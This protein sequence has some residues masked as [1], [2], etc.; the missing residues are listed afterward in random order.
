LKNHEAQK[1]LEEFIQKRHLKHSKQ[2]TQI[3]ETFLKTERH[4]SADELFA[5][6]KKKI[7]TIG[8]ATIY[9]TLRLLCE[10]GICREL[11]PDDGITRYEHLY[12]HEHHDHLICQKC[13]RFIEIADP[14]IEQLQ[15]KLARSKGFA[16]KKH[17][18]EMYG[19]C[20]R[21]RR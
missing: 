21:C 10:C 6:V 2:R 18:L 7:P 4:L 9:R 20:S 17:R 19:L 16:L 14:R 5:L 11:K 3:L 15:Q 13:G 8:Y 12:G 1:V